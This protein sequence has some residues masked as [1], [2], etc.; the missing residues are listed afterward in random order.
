VETGPKRRRRN[1][2]ATREIILE[3]ARKLLA[4]DGPEGLSVVSVTQAAGVNRG[5]IYVHFESREKLIAETIESVSNLLL[6]SVYADQA[7]LPETDV[8]AIDHVALTD[9]LAGFAISNPDLCRVWL[10]QVLASPDPGSDP[11][12][13][14]YVSSLMRFAATPL[15]KPGLD[16]EV[17]AVIVLAGTFLW[18]VWANAAT[19]DK[20]GRKSAAER[21]SREL[22]R[23]SM[24]GSMVAEHQAGGET[25]PPRLSQPD[26]PMVKAAGTDRAARTDA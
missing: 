26:E 16:A 11:F 21:F 24:H 23:L 1:P 3:A 6:Q 19:L 25:G 20:A 14:K 4:S 2:E 17:L 9:R 5:T 7:D 8:E 18:P 10:L 12:W 13:R 15:A 22:L